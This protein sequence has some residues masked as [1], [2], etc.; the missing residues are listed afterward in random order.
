MNCVKAY[1]VGLYQLP[2]V[3]SKNYTAFVYALRLEDK[4]A[5]DSRLELGFFLFCLF[6]PNSLV[7]FIT[8][9]EALSK[10][11]DSLFRPSKSIDELN[12]PSLDR[13]KQNILRFIKSQ[14]T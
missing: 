8:N 1:N 13:I 5:C 4:Y 12:G 9:L 6:I 11:F 7:R 10:K 3:D 14:S 2:A